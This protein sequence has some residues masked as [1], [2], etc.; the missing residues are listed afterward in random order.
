MK[1]TILIVDDDPLFISDLTLLLGQEYNCIPAASDNDA[2]SRL[3]AQ[4]PDL[5]LLDVHLDDT[6]SGMEVLLTL[7]EKHS[8]IPVI[9]MSD[10]PSVETVIKAM[11]LGAYSFIPKNSGI[12]DFAKTIKN[13]LEKTK[14]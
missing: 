14:N 7:H 5:I 6:A 1:P 11:E 4:V 12:K 2:F 8:D 10:R 9:M 13:I 3:R